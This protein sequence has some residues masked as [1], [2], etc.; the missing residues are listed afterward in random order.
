MLRF[1]MVRGFR[2]FVTILLV[3]TFAFVVL[4]MS[5]DPA[6]SIMGPDAPPEAI[7]AFRKN[8]GLDDPLW[9]QYL[10]YF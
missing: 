4:R 10:R 1:L 7:A 8:W 6:Q 9:Q 5:G 3:V 2:A